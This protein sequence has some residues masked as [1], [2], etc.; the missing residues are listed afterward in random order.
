MVSISIGLEVYK[1]KELILI[2]VEN[3][4]ENRYFP[5][6][7]SNLNDLHGIFKNLWQIQQI[8]QKGV[9]L[10]ILIILLNL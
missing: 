10:I 5:A 4:E 7:D 6:V 8:Q 2:S 3:W 9:L 1:W